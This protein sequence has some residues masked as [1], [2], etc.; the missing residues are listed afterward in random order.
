MP[1][2]LTN[3]PAT[4]QRLMNTVLRDFIELEFVMVFVDDILIHSKNAEDHIQHVMK[5]INRLKANSLKIKR[6]KCEI[7]KTSVLFLVQV[8]SLRQHKARSEEN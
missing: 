8:I 4:F 1:M 5:V 2:G 3:S 6:S 7:A